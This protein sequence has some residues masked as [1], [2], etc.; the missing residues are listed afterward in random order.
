M[1]HGQFLIASLFFT[2]DLIRISEFNVAFHVYTLINA[3][4]P[5]ISY[6][7]HNMPSKLDIYSF[8]IITVHIVITF[9]TNIIRVI[10]LHA[11][12]TLLYKYA[13]VQMEAFISTTLQCHFT[14]PARDWSL[15][16]NQLKFV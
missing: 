8:L 10:I 12:K 4:V 2:L 6:I 7:H 11:R 13:V 1:L 9:S 5:Q 16:A 14:K 15:S 3:F